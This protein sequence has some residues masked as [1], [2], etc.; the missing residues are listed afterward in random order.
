[1]C[2]NERDTDKFLYN[3][4]IFHTNLKRY[5]FFFFKKER[6]CAKLI[7]KLILQIKSPALNFA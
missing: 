6:Q 7:Q 4:K 2:W 3:E 5:D 1:M